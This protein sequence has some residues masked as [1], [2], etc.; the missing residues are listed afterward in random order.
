M[1]LRIRKRKAEAYTPLED[2][3]DF[4]V[5]VVQAATMLDEAAALAIQSGSVEDML[6]VAAGWMEIGINML[7][8]PE[9][10]GSEEGHEHDVTSETR[11]GGFAGS[12]P[13][14]DAEEELEES[15]GSR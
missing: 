14:E 10:D 3:I 1:R 6:K 9:E 8:R 7:T 11:G 15:N 13:S 4:T 5:A 2:Q 12:Q